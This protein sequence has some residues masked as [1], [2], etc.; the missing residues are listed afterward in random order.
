MYRNTLTCSSFGARQRPAHR[1]EPERM[2]LRS[3]RPANPA[4]K[5]S[6]SH[7]LANNPTRYIPKVGFAATPC[8]SAT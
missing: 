6:I 1:K 3:T 7:G 4:A 2:P 5:V 8:K